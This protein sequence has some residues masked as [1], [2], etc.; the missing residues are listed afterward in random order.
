MRLTRL[1]HIFR[2]LP[3]LIKESL[4][5]KQIPKGQT[6]V[7]DGTLLVYYKL[8]NKVIYKITTNV[9]LVEV[10]RSKA[11]NVRRL[12]YDEQVNVQDVL[13][14][15]ISK[16]KVINI[17]EISELNEKIV[18]K[19][20]KDVIKYIYELEN[21]Y[22]SYSYSMPNRK[23]HNYTENIN[24]V[25]NLIDKTYNRVIKKLL[26]D[27]TLVEQFTSP[28]TGEYGAG[29]Y[30][31]HYYLARDVV[32]VTDQF[33]SGFPSLEYPG[34]TQIFRMIYEKLFPMDFHFSWS[35]SFR[36]E[37]EE[38]ESV[39]LSDKISTKVIYLTKEKINEEVDL[40]DVLKYEKYIY[41]K[42]SYLESVE[43]MESFHYYIG[44]LI[45]QSLSKLVSN[46]LLEH[47]QVINYQ[48]EKLDK[49]IAN[50]SLDHEQVV[51]YVDQS[52]TKEI[53][54]ITLNSS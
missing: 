54:S 3:Y 42:F 49:I 4:F 7:C 2:F 50:V 21:I 18:E 11:V 41:N 23:I 17:N 27:V 8:R 34:K 38:S 26:D 39:S 13:N 19:K 24:L 16:L 15:P 30:E 12:N 37:E 53:S 40:Y 36:K 33:E 28:T 46:V 47:E 20:A 29:I 25:E 43:L 45:G 32:I 44:V 1:R 5:P 31:R 9:N 22:E 14:N 35:K 6:Y 10:F 52:V 51:N 48:S